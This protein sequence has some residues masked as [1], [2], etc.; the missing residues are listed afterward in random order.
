MEALINSCNACPRC[1]NVKRYQENGLGFCKMGAMPKIARAAPHFWEEPCVSG[2]NGSGAIFFSGCILKCVYCQ[3]YDISKKGYGE[4][5]TVQR[6][7]EIY[8]EL[9]C[10]GVHNI[11]LVNPTHFV[12]AI[13]QSLKIYRPSV[14]I[15]YNCGGY[16]SI[17]TINKLSGF[18]DV[19]LPDIKYYDGKKARKYSGVENYFE[20]VSKAVIAMAEQTGL[21]QFDNDGLI[22]SGTIIRHLILPG[23]TNDSIS[24]L[25]WIDENLSNKVL[26]SLMGQYTPQESCVTH[27]EINRRLTKR[28]YNKVQNFLFST[29]LNGFV[30]D[31]SSADKQYIPQFNLEGVK[32]G[33]IIK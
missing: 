25:K 28:E 10:Q 3:N 27:N 5:I 13:I 24:I 26:V 32:Q 6:L 11:N 21:P 16:E 29:N 31:L 8:R 7:A 30:Q 1:C 22:K 15:I 4:S 33:G 17:E 2:T 18:I 20:V 19:Y 14:P 12:E 9:E 23:S